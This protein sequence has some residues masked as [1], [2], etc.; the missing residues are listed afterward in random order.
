MNQYGVVRG[1]GTLP[2]AKRGTTYL[3]KVSS[4]PIGEMIRRLRLETGRRRRLSAQTAGDAGDRS[5][6]P[7]GP[8]CGGVL[9]EGSDAPPVSSLRR[10]RRT[11]DFCRQPCYR[12]MS[13]GQ[14]PARASSHLPPCEP[15]RPAT[16]GFSPE[17]E[18][19]PHSRCPPFE[20][21]H[22]R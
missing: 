12:R 4:S 22:V 8:F 16:S 18:H 17:V 6:Q 13:E 3:Q 21:T 20:V 14:P 2:T 7:F 9:S 10:S 11:T 5:A 19:A 15:V 1:R